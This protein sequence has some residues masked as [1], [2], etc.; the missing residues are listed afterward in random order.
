MKM[1]L[2]L[3]QILTV[4]QSAEPPGRDAEPPRSE[5]RAKHDLYFKD[6]LSVLIMVMDFLSLVASQQIN[7]YVTIATGDKIWT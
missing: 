4:L 3:P 6:I 1:I 2:V 7:Q 5:P